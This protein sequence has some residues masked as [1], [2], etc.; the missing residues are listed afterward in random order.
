MF[1]FLFLIFTFNYTIA[2]LISIFF[3][4]SNIFIQKIVKINFFILLFQYKSSFSIFFSQFFFWWKSIFFLPK[5]HLRLINLGLKPITQYNQVSD[6][7]KTFDKNID[8]TK[9]IQI[10]R[11]RKTRNSASLWKYIKSKSNLEPLTTTKKRA[12]QNQI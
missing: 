8:K 5:E 1:L 3:L 9:T 6:K 7:T 2:V 12:I 11:S 4:F 10:H